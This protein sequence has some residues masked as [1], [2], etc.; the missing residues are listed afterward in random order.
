MVEEGS[1]LGGLRVG[2]VLA[3]MSVNAIDG[4]AHPLDE[5]EKDIGG[6]YG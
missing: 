5:K 1:S 2:E 6:K 4:L 3:E